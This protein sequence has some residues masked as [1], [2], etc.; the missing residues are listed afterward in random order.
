MSQPV[1][2]W[3]PRR[4]FKRSFF[5]LLVLFCWS[6]KLSAIALMSISL[7]FRLV[8]VSIKMFDSISETFESSSVNTSVSGLLTTIYEWVMLAWWTCSSIRV[9]ASWWLLWRTW[10]RTVSLL[11][12]WQTSLWHV[13]KRVLFPSKW[14]SDFHSVQ[15]NSVNL[16]LFS[17]EERSRFHCFISEDGIVCWIDNSPWLR[18][19]LSTSLIELLT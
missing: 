5:V 11:V 9:S 17:L 12:I 6:W 10:I 7:L 1:K 2:L 15:I 18:Q 19:F 16:F 14:A 3:K 8:P 4:A 13:T